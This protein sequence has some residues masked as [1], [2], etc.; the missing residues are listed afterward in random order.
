MRS[1]S[2]LASI[3]PLPLFCFTSR[4]AVELS[5]AVAAGILAGAAVA[6]FAMKTAIKAFINRM[7]ITDE[8]A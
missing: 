1:V 2:R 3:L 4:T 8:T 7:F 6:V 5:G